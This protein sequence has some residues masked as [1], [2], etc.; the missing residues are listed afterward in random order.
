MLLKWIVFQE[1]R[2]L[3]FQMNKI[4]TVQKEVYSILSF[5]YCFIAMYLKK[6]TYILRS[7]SFLNF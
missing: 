6:S 7:E 3:N 1:T 2:F 5:L 4:T